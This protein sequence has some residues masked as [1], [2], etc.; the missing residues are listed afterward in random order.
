MPETTDHIGP[1]V[2]FGAAALFAGFILLRAIW[3][4]TEGLQHALRSVPILMAGGLIGAGALLSVFHNRSGEPLGWL[5]GSEAVDFG[6]SEYGV[7]FALFGIAA[8]SALLA[9]RQSGLNRVLFVLLGLAAIVIAGEEMSWGQWIFG[10]S[11]PETLAAVNLQNET[12]LHNLVDPRLYDIV[13]AAIGWS[14]L[15]LALIA[16]GFIQCPPHSPD[17]VLLRLLR[18]A[19]EWLRNSRYG[20]I[21]TISAAVL[22]QHELFEE[23]SEFVFG[24][25]ALL[26]FLHLIKPDGEPAHREVSYA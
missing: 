26:F 16:Y 22:L 6:F 21:T 11:T 25:A 18:A 5:F 13:Y 24:F 12:N 14:T 3:L 1:L 7:V 8:I 2:S 15:V 20:L 10:W 19:G 9:I 23:Y 4:K 17:F